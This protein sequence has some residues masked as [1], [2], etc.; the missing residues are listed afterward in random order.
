[1][2]FAIVCVSFLEFTP[3]GANSTAVRSVRV[4]RPL[5]TITKIPQL[6]V[7]TAKA[8]GQHMQIASQLTP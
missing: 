3:V 8:A 5:R 1:M 6:K 4:L 7:C 2:D